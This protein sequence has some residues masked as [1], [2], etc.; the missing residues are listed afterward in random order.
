MMAIWTGSINVPNIVDKPAKPEQFTIPLV[1]ADLKSFQTKAKALT[2]PHGT[3]ATSLITK[4]TSGSGYSQL[5]AIDWKV[6]TIT[7]PLI[8]VRF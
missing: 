1:T 4:M 2:L 7:A 6:W 8:T 5:R 3:E